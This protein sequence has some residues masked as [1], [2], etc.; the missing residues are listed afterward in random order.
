MKP[1]IRNVL[2]ETATSNTKCKDRTM[3][4]SYVDLDTGKV[5]ECKRKLLDQ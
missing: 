2:K 4:K 3:L 5:I 1:L